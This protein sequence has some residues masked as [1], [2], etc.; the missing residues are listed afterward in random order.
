MADEISIQQSNP[1]SRK[2]NKILEMRL[3]ND[4]D[5]VDAL[6]ALSTF[7]TEN[8]LRERRNLRGDI[9]KRSL[10]VNEQFES[11]FRDVK[12][13][14]D[15]VHSDIQSMSKCCEEMTTRL[16]M[17][18]EQTSDLI[19]KTTKLQAESQKVQLKQKVA[20]A[21]LDRFQLKPHE[22]EALKNSRNE[23]ITEEFFSALSRVK[24]IHSDCKLLLR[25]KQQTAGLEIMES[26]ALFME[27]AY[28]R[29]Y[30]WTQAE[31]RGLTGDVPE[32]MP[33][34]QNAMAVLQNRPV[35]L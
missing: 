29:L 17:A 2:L 18:R 27:S 8:N 10:Y 26:M 33:N 13:Q 14:L 12:E 23:P 32:I 16:K 5:L 3:D 9:E 25:T 35:L 30:R 31:C 19:S 11:A 22:T 15:L 24:V 1:L 28:E 34:L 6:K 7:F 21:F 20:D 4:K